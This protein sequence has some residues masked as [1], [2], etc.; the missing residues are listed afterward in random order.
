MGAKVVGSVYA[1]L[2]NGIGAISD[3]SMTITPTVDFDYI[4]IIPP[5]Y[6]SDRAATATRVPTV[7]I[8]KGG[9]GMVQLSAG[10]NNDYGLGDI[11]VTCNS[12]SIT[13]E[14]SSL[15]SKSTFAC[16]IVYYKYN[17]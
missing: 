10:S 4:E 8:A 1:G 16:T 13:F 6:A 2:R 17:S 9:T 14:T 7:T 11:S 12:A 3:N 5:V 15:S